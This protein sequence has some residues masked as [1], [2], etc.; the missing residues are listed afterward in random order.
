MTIVLSLA[1]IFGTWGLA[2]L[3]GPKLANY[4][5]GDPLLE[6]LAFAS[7]IL[8]GASGATMVLVF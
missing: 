6:S 3:I 5:T 2:G 7:L 1:L 8:L 4:C